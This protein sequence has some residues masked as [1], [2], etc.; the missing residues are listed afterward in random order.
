M[1]KLEHISK[2]FPVEDRSLTSW[3]KKETHELRA[4]V[5][6]NLEVAEGE[7]LGIVGES[8]CGKSTLARMV[9]GITQPS[10]GSIRYRGKDLSKL[11]KRERNALETEIQMVFQDPFYSLNPRVKIVGT[12]G[13]A[14][15]Y[16]GMIDRRDQE[17]YVDRL[18]VR[19]GLDPSY[20]SRLPHQFSGG[21]RQRI[22]I[23]RALAV[24]PKLLVCDEAVAALDVSIQ[25][26]IL[27]LF[28]D[29]RDELKLTYVFISHNLGVIS[30]I[31]DRVA[32]M[33][34]GRIVEIGPRAEVFA[35]ARHPYTQGLIAEVPRVKASKRR[36]VGIP[37]E[38]PSPLSPPSGCAFHPRCQQATERCR[39]EAP[40]LKA[41]GSGHGSACHL[42]D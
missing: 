10:D 14:P 12:V 29:L 15:V 20:K 25:A 34:L 9:A 13:R 35:R 23:A 11:P 3:F 27:N 17:S 32:V 24:N 19:V 33:Y 18:L 8:G 41:V 2:S 7:V 22:G 40:S 30:H 31:C 42:N 37:G 26:Q 38:I 28:M 21:Q 36:Y 1:L 16:H 6:V 4:V 39:I 5:D